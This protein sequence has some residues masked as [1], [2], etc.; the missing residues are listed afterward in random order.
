MYS[1]VTG[2]T[3]P[4]LGRTFCAGC[5]R[6]GVGSHAIC[7]FGEIPHY[8]QCLPSP[9]TVAIAGVC[10]MAFFYW[11][12]ATLPANFAERTKMTVVEMFLR[13]TYMKPVDAMTIFGSTYHQ[14]LWTRTVIDFYARMLSP[15]SL[16]DKDLHI[17]DTHIA[18]ALLFFFFSFS[19]LAGVSVRIYQPHQPELRANDGLVLFIHGGG[20][21]VGEVAGYDLI[22]REMARRS[23]MVT[24]SVE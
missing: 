6:I 13:L 15:W 18:G 12:A 24:V 17:Y 14:M 21:V 1:N 23:R 9:Q 10:L 7:P 5:I 4:P 16:A 2:S 3:A 11:F 19:L 20:F 8:L 22:V